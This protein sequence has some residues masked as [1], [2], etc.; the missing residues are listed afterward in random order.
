MWWYGWSSIWHALLWPDL[1][2]SSPLRILGFPSD[3]VCC[4]LK[5]IAM[6]GEW[7]GSGC[8]CRVCLC[9]R[10]WVVGRGNHAGASNGPRILPD[11]TSAAIS[12]AMN[13]Q[14]VSMWGCVSFFCMYSR[15]CCRSS[16]MSLGCLY[17]LSLRTCHCNPG[18]RRPRSWKP[19]LSSWLKMC[20][21]GYCS[22]WSNWMSTGICVIICFCL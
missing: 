13:S 15:L 1:R 18:W 21:W 20:V 5:A 22:F 8:F 6:M 4:M 7:C 17:L 12:S 19:W 14:C 2:Q 11:F 3:P 9:V 16:S 10:R